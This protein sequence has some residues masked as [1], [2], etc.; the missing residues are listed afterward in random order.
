MLV[1]G[2]A[3]SRYRIVR[4]IGKGGMGE[5]YLAEDTHLRR[6]VA[7]KVIAPQADY[8]KLAEALR[9]FQREMQAIA[10]LDHP[11]I[12][13]LYDYGEDTV[14]GIKYTYMVMPFREDGTLEAWLEERKDKRIPP[15]FIEDVAQILS[16][17]ASALQCAHDDPTQILHLD[18]KL[19]NFLIRNNPEHPSYPDLLLADFGTT[20]IINATG[21]ITDTVRGSVAYM[22]PEQW[23]RNPQ[24]ASDQYALAIMIYE[25]LTYQKP[26][27]GT[28]EQLMYQHIHETPQP[29]STINPRIPSEVDGVILKALAKNYQNRYP[30]ITAFADAFKQA[31]VNNTDIRILLSISK[32]EAQTGVSYPL[33]LPNGRRIT[34]SVPS[35]TRDGQIIRQE[36]IGEP[37][38]AGGPP[39]ALIITI[40][41]KPT[42]GSDSDREVVN[43]IQS[44]SHQIKTL[45]Q[46]VAYLQTQ[47]S[48]SNIQPQ[49][50]PGDNTVQQA[51]R[52][53][54]Q[55]V[56][57]KV[58]TPP[59]LP[60]R[61]QGTA[62]QFEDIPQPANQPKSFQSASRIGQ[63][64]TE[65]RQNVSTTARNIFG[66]LTTKPPSSRTII[67][68]AILAILI[69]VSSAIFYAY[70]GNQSN[71]AANSNIMANP[72][73]YPSYLPGHGT[74]AL[75]DSL[76]GSNNQYNWDTTSGCNFSNGAYQVGNFQE[77]LSNFCFASS[78]NFSNFAFEVDMTINK[79]D[80]GGMVFRADS[81]NYTFYS[82]VP[83]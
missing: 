35:G 40:A 14:D 33:T 29:P 23:Q 21:D 66:R 61:N 47:L 10:R 54:Q 82:L 7:I 67:I 55:N 30:T 42:S 63:P 18:V 22:P 81:S 69:V 19:S 46:D 28:P 12:L 60:M 65:N 70:Q 78:S 8:R 38:Y 2:T 34:V 72:N 44:L 37:A 15:P 59:P 9:L 39:R 71:I 41:I 13:P 45:S 48:R 36:G 53:H 57:P 5:A 31:L 76:N 80:C 3:L 4:F 49:N 58:S 25:I 75:S 77:S 6:K 16:Q 79:S 50:Y 32:T 73:A 68:L 27:Q 43:H 26:F 17:A 64:T 83:V 51:H 1:A 62:T 11:H 24:P 52:G 56:S 74:L 20:K